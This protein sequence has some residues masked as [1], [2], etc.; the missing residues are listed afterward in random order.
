[1]SL[2]AGL[3]KHILHYLFVSTSGQCQSGWAFSAAGSLEGQH[4]QKTGKLVS[5][6]EQNLI[7][8]STSYGNNGCQGGLVDNAFKYIKTNGGIDTEASYPYE[9]RNMNCRFKTADVGAMD[10]GKRLTVTKRK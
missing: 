8:C 3:S 9:A 7:D 10:T 6:S 1:M 5:L 2:C 4:F